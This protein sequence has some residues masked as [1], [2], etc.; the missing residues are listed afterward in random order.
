MNSMTNLNGVN[1]N[2]ISMNVANVEDLKKRIVQTASIMITAMENAYKSLDELT[3]AGFITG[4]VRTSLEVS[5]ERMTQTARD[6]ANT[7]WKMD[8]Q[9]E[10]NIQ[11]TTAIDEQYANVFGNLASENPTSFFSDTDNV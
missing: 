4:T 8:Q 1:I 5:H 6:L 7:I 3:T 9:I 10:Q 11:E 2:T